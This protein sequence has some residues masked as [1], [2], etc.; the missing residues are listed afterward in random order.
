MWAFLLLAVGLIGL[1]LNHDKLKARVDH[2]AE[3]R[4]DEKQ[5]REERLREDL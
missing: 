2:E 4:L 1:W 5:A 3:R